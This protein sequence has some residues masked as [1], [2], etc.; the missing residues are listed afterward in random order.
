MTSPPP[1]STDE[2]ALHALLLELAA[3]ADGIAAARLCKRLGLRMSALLR[4]LAWLGDEAIG[5]R[6]G[7]GWVRL[8]HEG[9]RILVALTPAGRALVASLDP[10][11]PE[12]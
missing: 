4:M 2:A 7:P 3:H 10:P 9:P 8:R 12:R 6:P 1:S 11:P 5:E